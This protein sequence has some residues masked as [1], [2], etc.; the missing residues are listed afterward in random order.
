M[1]PVSTLIQPVGLNPASPSDHVLD[2]GYL[3]PFPDS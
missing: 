2:A 3:L 1:E